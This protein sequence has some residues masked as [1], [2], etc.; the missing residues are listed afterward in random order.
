MSMRTLLGIDGRSRGGVLLCLAVLFLVLMLVGVGGLGVALAG[1][2]PDR[3]DLV[4]RLQPPSSAHWLGPDELGRDLFT[5]IAD[6]TWLSVG[7][8]LLVSAGTAAAGI[9][10]GGM[11]AMVG[12]WVDTLIMRIFDLLLSLPALL[13]AIA[14]AAA[15]GPGLVNALFAL[16]I[17]RTPAF[18]RLARGQTLSLRRRAFVESAATFGAG[19]LYVLRQHIVPNILPVMTVQAVTDLAGLILAAAA[20]GFVGL[21]AQPPTPEWGALVASSR[22]YFEGSWWYPLF[23]GLALLLTATAF[24]LVGDAARDYLDPRQDR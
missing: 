19:R 5:R 3:V 9:L 2:A 8:A 21:G 16:M 24:N 15:L 14:L 13:V 7:G 4:V 22:F 23:P 20:L 10:V 12:G 1:Y 18:A 17:V 11:S 6:G